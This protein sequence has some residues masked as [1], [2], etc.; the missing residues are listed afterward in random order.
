MRLKIIAAL[1][2]CAL[3][4]GCAP[5][6]T[7][8]YRNQTSPAIIGAWRTIAQV[9]PLSEKQV[10]AYTK[11]FAT[12]QNVTPRFQTVSYQFIWANQFGY[13]SNTPTP[14]KSL[15]LHPGD[16]TTVSAI[17]PSPQDVHYSMR[18]CQT[19]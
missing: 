17:S 6:C 7:V 12:I 13:A 14:L 2:I 1:S 10:G 8:I 4:S 3:L 19:Q 18:V 15:I 16:I 9:T 11:V 5:T